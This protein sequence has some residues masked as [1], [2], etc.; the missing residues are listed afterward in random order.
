MVYGE[1]GE[2]PLQVTIDN[3]RLMSFGLRLL[4][5]ENILIGTY[6]KHTLFVRD[7]YKAKW[8]CRVKNISDNCG[9]SYLWLNQSMIDIN[10]SKQSIHMRIKDIALHNWYIYIYIYIYILTSSMCTM[11]FISCHNTL[12]YSLSFKI[13]VHCMSV[14]W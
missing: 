10:Q 1:V 3:K 8:L 13:P 11:Y 5:K 9:L 12:Y 7:V 14:M 2:L 4:N 6:C